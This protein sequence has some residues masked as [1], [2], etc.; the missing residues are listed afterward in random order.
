MCNGFVVG[1]E[2]PFIFDM[3]GVRSLEDLEFEL[4]ISYAQGLGKDDE[5]DTKRFVDAQ[6][7]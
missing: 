4:G 5:G 7:S 1:V 6:M 3:V 2:G